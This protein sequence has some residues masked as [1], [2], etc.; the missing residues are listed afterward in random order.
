[1]DGWSNFSY[2]LPEILLAILVTIALGWVIL[3]IRDLFRHSKGGITCLHCKGVSN[4]ISRHLLPSFSYD[5]DF[6]EGRNSHRQACMLGR[7]L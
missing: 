2:Y 3:V 7:G 4:K 6:Q 5:T 1:M